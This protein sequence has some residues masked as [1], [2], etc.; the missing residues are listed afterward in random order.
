MKIRSHASVM[1]LGIGALR[2]TTTLAYAQDA[3]PGNALNPRTV[4]SVVERDPEGL[5]IAVNSRTPTGLLIPPA[6][7]VK[8]PSKTSSGLLYRGTIEFGA[9]GIGGDKEAAKFREYKDL[10]SGLYLNNFTFMLE[11][12]KNGFH[13][14]AV[15]GGVAQNDQYYGVDLGRYNAWRIRGSFSEIPHVFTSTYH[16]LWDGQGSDTLALKGLRPG[17]TTDANTTQAN[18]LL[19]ISSTAASDLELERKRS[20]ARF[21][22]TLPA[23]WKAFATYGNERREGSRPF[24]AV[25]GGGGGGGNIEIPES[26][27]YTTQDVLA[28]LQFANSMTNL[29]VQVTASFFQNDIDTLTFENPLF[30]TTNTIQGVPST[31]FTRGQ[32]D[33]YPDNN[34]L[35]LKGEFG[36]KFPKFLKSRFTAV[37]SLARLEQNDNLIPWALEPLAG[38]TIN[39]VSTANVWNTTASLTRTSADAQ[40][41]TT[42]VDL[43]IILNPAQ[44]LAVKGKVRYFDT[45]NSTEFFACNPLT[46]QWGRLLNN[47]SGGSFVTPNLTVGNNPPGTLA[48]G[49]NGTGCTYAATQALGLA[50]SA[51]DVPIR[52]VPY[53]YRQLN[54]IVTAEYRPSRTNSLE[55]TYERENFQREYRDR[56]KTGEDKFRLGYVNRALENGTLRLS[57]EYGRRRGSD[58]LA[59]PLAEF[60]SISLGPI[61]TAATTNMASWLRNVD[62]FRRFD[63]ADRNQNVVNAR[64]NYGIAST[65][66]ASVAVQARDVEYPAS[67]YGRNEH[68]KLTSP[69]VELNWQPSPTTSA[70]GFYSYQQGAQHQAG[71]QPNACVMGNFYFFFSDGSVQTNATGVPPPAPTGTTLASTQ[72]V[73]PA[74]WRSLCGMASAVSPL[75][76]TSRT[77]DVS[78]KDHN[79]VTGLGLHYEAGKVLSDLAYTYSNGRTKVSYGYNPAA[80]G[81]NATQVALA[82]DGWSDLVFTQNIVEANAMVPIRK[83]LSLRL[84][85]RFEDGKIRDWH[86]DG[87]SV[88]PMPANNGAYLD[89]G[90]QDY[91]VHLFGALFRY[92]L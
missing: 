54:S 87:V 25:F 44:A 88:N 82:G 27:D 68:F 35:N 29:N 51:G 48:T 91:K 84:I 70:Y 34:Y 36:R 58:F 46:G 20:R 57:Y 23:N 32:F 17:G 85:Y 61:P 76:P 28:G 21:D 49:Y 80:L 69:S 52:S 39:G 78:Q 24:G 60:Y 72:Q 8:E 83:R 22:L 19:A 55:G 64:F 79:T 81:L 74:N 66:D 62:Q 3:T 1:I 14:D 7:L 6:P 2:L 47:G 15:G 41:D 12:P 53:E 89:F 75:F 30:I 65:L 43:G 77:W 42:L 86:Y 18:M 67:E 71:L 38:G 13:L 40:I 11:Q 4:S 16:S 92:E 33:L 63:V 10:E 37:A 59:T 73:V 56:D 31:T 50:P 90:P 5:G 45:D 26:I 9:I